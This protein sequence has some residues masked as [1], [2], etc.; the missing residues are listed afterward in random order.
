MG[1]RAT[2]EPGDA[3]A[4]APQDQAATIRD[5]M[6]ARRASVPLSLRPIRWE[7]STTSAA[8]IALLTGHG[9]DASDWWTMRWWSRAPVIPLVELYCRHSCHSP[10]FIGQGLR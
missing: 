2:G 6:A 3:A 5:E 4:A 1:T 8:R 7:Q 9:K 10:L